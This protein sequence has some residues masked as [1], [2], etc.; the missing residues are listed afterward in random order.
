M[1]I[2]KANLSR[3]LTGAIVFQAG[4]QL[5]KKFQNTVSPHLKLPGFPIPASVFVKT[6]QELTVFPREVW[7]SFSLWVVG[8]LLGALGLR[9][10]SGYLDGCEQPFCGDVSMSGLPENSCAPRVSLFPGRYTVGT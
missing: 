10:E 5:L 7:Y 9:Q 3:F 1:F 2:H 4:D 6:G 8:R